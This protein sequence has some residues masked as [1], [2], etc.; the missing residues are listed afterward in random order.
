MHSA[1][2]ILYD[3]DKDWESKDTI[4]SNVNTAI[5]AEAK[6][7]FPTVEITLLY[8]LSQEAKSL[9]EIWINP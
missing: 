9:P 7:G 1:A 5:S 4:E 6:L 2:N 8:G 3:C